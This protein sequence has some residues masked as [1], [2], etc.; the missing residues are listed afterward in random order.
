[1]WPFKRR[2]KAP[3]FNSKSELAFGGYTLTG[4]V[5]CSECDFSI[6]PTNWYGLTPTSKGVSPSVAKDFILDLWIDYFNDIHPNETPGC[7]GHAVIEVL[8]DTGP[9]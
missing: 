4:D 6:V 1:M 3:K 9:P 7:L 5:H 2:P 8:E